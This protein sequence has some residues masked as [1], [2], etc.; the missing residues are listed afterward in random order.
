LT[1]T[2]LTGTTT[3]TKSKTFAAIGAVSHADPLHH[4]GTL[5]VTPHRAQTVSA[6][7]STLRVQAYN[8]TFLTSC[9]LRRCYLRQR[10]NIEKL[11]TTGRRRKAA[12]STQLLRVPSDKRSAWLSTTRSFFS[13][14]HKIVG[15]VV[16]GQQTT[17]ATWIEKIAR[18]QPP[19]GGT[20]RKH[21][22]AQ[23]SGLQREHSDNGPATQRSRTTTGVGPRVCPHSRCSHPPNP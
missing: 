4:H 6:T 23:G 10:Y 2:I 16:C 8:T 7:T 20:Q 9:N 3:T 11:P 14:H 1:V 12:T 21:S 15:L 17:Y 19:S 18:P 5:R 22:V 13:P